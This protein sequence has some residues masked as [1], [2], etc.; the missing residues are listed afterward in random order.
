MALPLD[1]LKTWLLAGGIPTVGVNWLP[2]TPDDIVI[3]QGDGGTP[4][5]QNGAFEQG[6]ILIRSRSATDAD[7]EA[8]AIQVHQLITGVEQSFMAG[9]T[10]VQTVQ[11]IAGPPRY[12]SRDV[13]KRTTYAAIY[14]FT[15][16]TA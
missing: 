9:S 14:A 6:H 8:L 2:D 3:I 11:S 5:I 1:D 13:D 16:P 15:T 12:L 10:F 4:P 7:A